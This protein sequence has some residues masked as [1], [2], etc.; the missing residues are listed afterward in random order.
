MDI[1]SVSQGRQLNL[2]YYSGNQAQKGEVKTQTEDKKD[3]TK[4]EIDKAVEKLNKLLED[5]GT[6]AEYT[7]HD[8]FKY[9]VMVKIIDNKTKE[10]ILE[11]P[12]KKV[13]DLIARMVEAAESLFDKKA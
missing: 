5:E 6:H 12:P 2:D 1:N 9:D 7:I 4:K 8:K 10:V 13:L 3:F 11:V